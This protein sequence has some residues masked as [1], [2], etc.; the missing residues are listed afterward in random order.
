MP[1]RHLRRAALVA[2]L[3]A[4]LLTAPW[5][6]AALAQPTPPPVLTATVGPTPEPP[7]LTPTRT[8]G[9]LVGVGDS[10]ETIVELLVRYGWLG[11]VGL[12]LFGAASF[13]L[14]GYGEGFRDWFKALGTSHATTLQTTAEASRKRKLAATAEDVGL[15]A[16]LAWVQAECN[17]LPQKPL[18]D[19]HEDLRL[20][21]IY[22][23]LRVV[24]RD[25]M[26]RFDAFSLGQFEAEAEPQSRAAALEALAQS[27]GIFRLLSDRDCL[28]P[29]TEAPARGAAPP[30]EPSLTTRLLL[31]GKAGSGKTTT[32]HFAALMLAYDQQNANGIKARTDL[33]LHTHERL[34][35]VYL[36]LT[37]LTRY[38]LERYRADRS[39]LTNCP[40]DL[41][42]EWLDFDLPR[43][44]SA[45]PVGLVVERL[46]RGN[47]LVL[48]DGLDETGDADERMF[49][50]HLIANLVQACPDNRYIVASRPFEGVAQGLNGFSERHLSPLNE[51]EMQQLLEQWFAAV[52]TSTRQA[53]HRSVNQERDDLWG[54]LT[55]NPRLFDMAMNPLLLTS[56]AIL[57]H[58]GDSLPT[59]RAKIYDRLLALTIERWRKAELRRGLPPD[60]RER[61]RSIYGEES[62]DD[63]RLRLQ[64][65]AAWMLAAQQREIRL[66]EVVTQLGPIYAANRREWGPDKCRNYIRDLMQSLA[67]H[68]GL[69]QERDQQ[70][71]FIHFTL[72]EYLVARHY[73]EIRD[74]AGLLAQRGEARWRESILLAVGHWATRGPR[75]SAEQALQLLLTAGDTASLFL[76]AEALDEA[77]AHKV[78]ALGQSLADCQRRLHALAFFPATCPDPVQRNR[79]ASLLD[80]LD[81]DL[82]RPGLDLTNDDYWAARLEP[83]TFSMGD[84]QGEYADEKPAFTCRIS[85]PYRL[86]RFPVTNRQYFGFVEALAGRGADQALQAAQALRPLMAQHEQTPEQFRPRY[87]PGARYRAG[88]GNH[89]VVGVTWYAATAYAWWADAY[90]RALGRLLPGE[91]VRLPTEAEWERAAAYPPVLPGG[92]PRAER[93][94]YPWGDVWPDLTDPANERI[95]GSIP[96]NTNESGIGGTSVV[97]IFPHGVAACGAEELAGNVWEWCSTPKLDYRSPGE[98]T[99]ETL[100]TVNGRASSSYVLR[101]GAWGYSQVRARCA[102]RGD[103]YP[104]NDNGVDGLRLAHLFSSPVA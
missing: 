1:Y 22:V 45:I 16:Y 24:E 93:R 60:E 98:P 99:A 89:P 23:P 14:S 54:R 3:F 19:D 49:V 92:N 85:R 81:G 83:G 42:Y 11:A 76:A 8:A 20:E 38:L 32:L 2:V 75:Q 102:S 68:S 91:S 18:D 74:I 65:L 37:L 87:W 35:P 36:K 34:L 97:G 40:A 44:Q 55:S 59:E 67:L 90:L 10:P 52:G 47:C 12:L 57:V 56:M 15:A 78:M 21:Q 82:V 88:E 28:P 50:K 95:R 72:Q 66:N 103:N 101:G 64:T 58:G 7:E 79:A 9:A 61:E 100:Y 86:A 62:E 30:P 84:D 104:H 6:P 48:C 41:V 96:A 53:P 31:V 33:D 70:Y 29:P 26:K 80:R 13:L 51:Q 4:L 69:I 73:D 27:Q 77:N 71:S 5:L 43:Q 94:T 25:Q 39:R 17:V 46:K 63:V